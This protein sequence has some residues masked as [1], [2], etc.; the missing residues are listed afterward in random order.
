V[1][2]D[3]LE[4]DCAEFID[5]YRG[6]A[7][8]TL[9]A[10]ELIADVNAL[11]RQN[12]LLFPADVALLLKV[13]LTLENLG[14]SLDPAFV[15]SAHVQP[16]VNGAARSA[17]TGLRQVTRLGT[18]LVRLAQDLPRDLRRLRSQLRRG[19]IGVAFDLSGLDR[20]SAQIDRSVNHLTI[21]MITAALIVGTSVSLTVSGGP[22]VLGMPLFGV[23]GFLSSIVV[24][25]WWMIVTRRRT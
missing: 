24:G 13:F 16:F 18:E 14:R 4:Q 1:E 15:V 22:R 17:R 12:G 10:S 7:L 11:A 21:G 19:K 8:Q 20:F 3:E 2:E 6:C 23:A 25:L 9:R 5:R